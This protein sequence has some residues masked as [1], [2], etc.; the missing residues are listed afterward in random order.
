M[1]HGRHWTIAARCFSPPAAAVPELFTPHGSAQQ[2]KTGQLPASTREKPPHSGDGR[3]GATIPPPSR[4][5]RLADELLRIGFDGDADERRPIPHAYIECHIEQAPSWPTPASTSASSR[6][7][8]RSPGSGSPSAARP[9]TPAPPPSRPGTGSEWPGSGWPRPRSCPSIPAS[10]TCSPPP[11]TTS[12]CPTCA[13]CPA[14]GTTP[15]RS[16]RSAPPPWCSWPA[17]TAASATPPRILHP[18]RLRQRHRRAGQRGPAL[19]RP[20]MT[21]TSMTVL[22]LLDALV[23]IDSVNPGLDSA[24]GRIDQRRHRRIHHPGP[25]RVHRRT[26]NPSRGAP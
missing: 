10:R 21:A 14:P 19:G 16:R 26:A 8:S 20:A 25:L 2:N 5:R 11:P 9:R 24:G 12:A 17:K 1:D 3:A 23:R 22:D 6:A 4:P 13:P 15:R 7:C 18:R